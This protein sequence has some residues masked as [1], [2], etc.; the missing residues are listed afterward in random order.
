MCTTTESRAPSYQLLEVRAVSYSGSAWDCYWWCLH[1]L[2]AAWPV[3]RAPT[4]CPTWQLGS[5]P[6]RLWQVRAGRDRGCVEAL[7]TYR[8]RSMDVSLTFQGLVTVLA[9]H[10]RCYACSPRATAAGAAAAPVL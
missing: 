9:L 1:L 8:I 7:S 4:L 3:R 5:W 6:T 2:P 10:P